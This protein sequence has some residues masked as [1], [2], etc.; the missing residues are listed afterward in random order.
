AREYEIATGGGFDD[1]PGLWIQPTIID[2]PPDDANVVRKEQFGP[3]KPI[4]EWETEDEVI[5]RVKPCRDSEVASGLRTSAHAECIGRRL[6][7]GFVWINSFEKPLPI[8]YFSGHRESGIGGEWGK[9][10]LLS[11]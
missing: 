2:R 3:L 4:I 11:Y 10:G 9:Q 6:E 7:T 8:A 1:G 5:K